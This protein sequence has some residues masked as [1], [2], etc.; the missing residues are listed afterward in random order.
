MPG[1]TNLDTSRPRFPR[2]PSPPSLTSLNRRGSTA[3]SSS[4]NSRWST[5]VLGVAGLIGVVLASTPAALART[6]ITFWHDWGGQGGQVIQSL[7]DRFNQSQN[8]V[9][10]EV[11]LQS[12]LGQKLAVAVA[13]N[14]APDVVLLDRFTT[15]E[16]AANGLLEPLD[17]F[18]RTGGIDPT[19]FFGP[20][21]QEARWKQQQYGIPTNT[22][23]RA[24][25]YLRSTLERAGLNPQQPPQTWDEL[26]QASQKLT[27]RSGER[28]QQVGY[29]PYW[30]NVSLKEYIW[31]N[32]GEI[33]SPDFK[34]VTF[35]SDA[36]VEALQWVAQFVQNYG[37]YNT[38][39]QFRSQ[40][41]WSAGSLGPVLRGQLGLIWEGNWTLGHVQ[42]N[43][44][45]IYRQDL[46]AGL[47]PQKVRR[48][49]L[50][51]GHGLVIPKGSKAPE[52]AWRFIRYFTDV[53]AQL[54]FATGTGVMPANRRAAF[55]PRLASDPVL[56]VF[57]QAMDY[58]HVRPAHPAF[59]QIDSLMFEAWWKA[60]RAESAAR[61]ALE[62]VARRA[63]AILDRY[64]QQFGL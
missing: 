36:G 10:V 5:P 7:V 14:A 29:V 31:Q 34:Q 30:G 35:A 55:D 56:R 63:Q 26:V 61:P 38:L 62:D 4:R 17:R 32:G 24:L 3:M 45:E 23:A 52:A 59:P 27:Q 9:E 15:S 13:A 40:I 57:F 6:K 42:R 19:N 37:G 12:G 46:M 22:D 47:P 1:A 44:P 48:A 49:T 2:R 60:I 50:S 20:I 33:L 53:E 41:D 21:W 39:E 11:A 51:G 28:L 8:E 43:F 54:S 25:L 18:L 64:N 16:F 58:T